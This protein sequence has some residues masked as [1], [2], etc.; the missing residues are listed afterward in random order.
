MSK[1]EIP[2]ETFLRIKPVTLYDAVYFKD[3]NYLYNL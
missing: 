3:N 1:R 2:K